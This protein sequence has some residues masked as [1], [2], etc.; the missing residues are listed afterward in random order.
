MNYAKPEVMVLAE[1]AEAVQ[2][3][4]SKVTTPPDNLAVRGTGPAYEAD[5]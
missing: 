1:A 5:E 2:T 4:N 3:P